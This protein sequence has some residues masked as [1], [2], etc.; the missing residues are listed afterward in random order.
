MPVPAVWPFVDRTFVCVRFKNVG[1][2]DLVNGGELRTE[3]SRLCSN[4]FSG[5]KKLSPLHLPTIFSH[6]TYAN[7]YAR[8]PP[9]KSV[10]V[11][12]PTNTLFRVFGLRFEVGSPALL[13]WEQLFWKSQTS[14]EGMTGKIRYRRFHA[15]IRSSGG[16]SCLKELLL[17][18]V[19]KSLPWAEIEES[20]ELIVC[21][22]KLAFRRTCCWIPSNLKSLRTCKPML[23]RKS[24]FLK[25]NWLWA[26]NV[27]Q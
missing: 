8:A 9:R 15:V 24:N 6:Q 25:K 13:E 26:T 18:A 1:I 10:S 16:K 2:D 20:F 4:H 7:E 19:K 22:V 27:T 11:D 14:Q 3:N 23:I 5:K 21:T 12:D 17:R